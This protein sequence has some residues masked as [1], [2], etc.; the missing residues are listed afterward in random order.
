MH[1]GSDAR[2][3]DGVERVYDRGEVVESG[4]E[5]TVAEQCSL[6]LMLCEPC[7]MFAMRACGKE[8][9]KLRSDCVCVNG[10]ELTFL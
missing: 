6:F 10:V 3:V 7:R 5:K 8:R 4:G 2:V 9:A 1:V